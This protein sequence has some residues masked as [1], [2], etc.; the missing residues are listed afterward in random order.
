[1]A[2]VTH[3]LLC[4]QELFQLFPERLGKLT[5]NSRHTSSLKLTVVESFTWIAL[6]YLKQKVF[7]YIFVAF[8]YK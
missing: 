2:V 8:K 6:R 5:S 4:G 3:A 1:M 7:L